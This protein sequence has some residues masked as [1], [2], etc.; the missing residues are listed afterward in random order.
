MLSLLIAA[1]INQTPTTRE[2]PCDGFALAFTS[3]SGI[4]TEDDERVEVVTTAGRFTV[5]LAPAMFTGVGAPRSMPLSKAVRCR[6]GWWRT[7]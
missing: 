4:P 2:L 3:A 5:P 6:E 1:L 7:R